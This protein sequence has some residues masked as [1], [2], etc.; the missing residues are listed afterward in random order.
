MSWFIYMI[1]ADDDS[2]YTGITTDV[3]RRFEEHRAG[4]KGAAYFNGRKPLEIVFTEQ[5]P[6]RATASRR[7]AEIKKL[8]RSQKVA[9]CL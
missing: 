8:K 5:H 7:E 3:D 1:R 9:L 4:P 2:L 6:D